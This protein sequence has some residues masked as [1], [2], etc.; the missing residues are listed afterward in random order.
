MKAI[1]LEEKGQP[2][3][4][5]DFEAPVPAAGEVVVHLKAAALNHRDVWI[6]KG[7]YP[8]I[9]TP[10]ILGSDGA[11][12]AEGREVII[13]PNIGWGDNQEHQK[14]DYTILG[15]PSFGTM[16][17]QISVPEDRLV[18][19]PGHLSW[20]EAAALPLGGLTAYR[21]IFTKGNCKAGDKVLISGIGGG[22]ALFAFQ[23]ALAA[24]A[25]V[26]VTSGSADKL[27]RAIEM[28]AKGGANYREEDWHKTLGKASGGFDLIIDSAGGPGFARFPKICN[29]GARIVT[30]GGTQGKVPDFS[31]QLIFWKQIA[32]LGTS[33]GSDQEF[34]DMATFVSKHKIKPVVDQVFPIAEATKAFER[35]DQGKQFGKIVL[36]I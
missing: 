36:E 13:N 20:A 21:A 5:R 10:G 9:K 33:M 24:G 14:P 31:P 17:E 22:V 4:Y 7:M 28:G 29:F 3:G 23:F 8:G 15:M 30:Y 16:A 34:Q 19:K 1:V 18:D 27:S 2:I 6:T 32:I 26:Y 12:I 25:E 11:G 35:M